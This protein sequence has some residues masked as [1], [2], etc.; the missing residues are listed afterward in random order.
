M[1]SLFDLKYKSFFLLK[2]VYS[3]SFIITSW[4]HVG[5]SIKMCVSARDVTTFTKAWTVSFV[6]L[7][8]NSTQK[9]SK[10]E[11]IDIYNLLFWL[12]ITELNNI[13]LIVVES[14]NN[15]FRIKSKVQRSHA[16]A[17]LWPNSSHIIDPT[18]HL[19]QN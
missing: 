6:C 15:S 13:M 3:I 8:I 18:L 14:I 16:I 10:W 9:F 7:L 4:I 19:Y 1:M 17:N 2:G 11:K 5:I 12:Y